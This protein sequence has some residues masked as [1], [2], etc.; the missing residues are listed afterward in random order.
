MSEW[1]S[2]TKAVNK[3]YEF[4]VQV[5]DG[6]D[7]DF[8]TYSLYAISRGAPTADMDLVTADNIASTNTNNDI[9]KMLDAS[10]TN[11]RRPALLTQSTGLGRV[12][13]KQF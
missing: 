2:R 9:N 5:T 8:K 12:K 3:N 7:V 13:I 1:D 10:Q 11:L 4:T 6:K